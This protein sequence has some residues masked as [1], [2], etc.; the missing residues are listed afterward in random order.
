MRRPST[1]LFPHFPIFS[2][3]LSRSLRSK[4]PPSSAS[5]AP[6][7]LSAYKNLPPTTTPVRKIPALLNAF[8]VLQLA[9]AIIPAWN[10]QQHKQTNQKQS[11]P[12]P[13]NS[14]KTSPILR[15]PPSRCARFI[16]SRSSNSPSSSNQNHSNAPSRPSKKSPTPVNASS[17][18]KPAPW[19]PPALPTSS[20]TNQQPPPTPKSSAKPP[21][22]SYAS[23]KLPRE[24][25]AQR[26]E[27]LFLPPLPPL[28]PL[29]LLLPLLRFLPFHNPHP[30]S[31]H[32]CFPNARISA[33][34]PPNPLM[35]SSV[36]FSVLS[37]EA[38][39]PVAPAK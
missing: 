27:G 1:L 12:S 9:H 39:Y 23:T 35:R 34:Y 37:L 6:P 3:S 18:P 11:Q 10:K 14:S 13:T 25:P 17:N 28:P 5:S 36:T 38:L 4:L 8:L 19:Q 30:P 2:S 21:I 22:N 32:R 29:L 31:L 26:T 24:L 7:A 15:C 16:A 20:K 33:G